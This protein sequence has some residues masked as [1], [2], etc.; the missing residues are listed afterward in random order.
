MPNK[1]MSSRGYMKNK[2]TAKGKAMERKH[3][4]DALKRKIK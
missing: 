2:E 1:I 3:Q 4:F